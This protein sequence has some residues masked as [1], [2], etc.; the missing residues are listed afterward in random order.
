MNI[1]KPN[2]VR[3]KGFNWLNI[4]LN[5]EIINDIL[6]FAPKLPKID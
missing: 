1:Y 5:D 3:H 2:T 6:Q 4:D